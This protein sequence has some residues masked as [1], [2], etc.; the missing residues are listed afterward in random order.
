MPGAKTFLHVPGKLLVIRDFLDAEFCARICRRSSSSARAPARVAVGRQSATDRK[1]RRANYVRLPPYDRSIL[2]K[3]M[4][5]VLPGLA[6]G[7]GLRVRGMQRVQILSYRR[8]DFFKVHSDNSNRPETRA[9]IKRRKL[10]LILFMNRGGSA[11][12]KHD[13]SGG[14]LHLYEVKKR[15]AAVAVTGEPGMLVAFRSTTLHEVTPIRSGER[16]TAVSWVC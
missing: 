6:R 7:F 15:G 9:F 13:Y 5:S 8:G 12:N 4:L 3:R 10:S 16:L 11:R 1:V 2:R 14:N